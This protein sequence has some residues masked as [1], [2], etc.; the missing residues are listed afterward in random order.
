MATAITIA[1]AAVTAIATAMLQCK[2][3][4][5]EMCYLLQFPLNTI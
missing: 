3:I 1:V 2:I 4:N 5:C